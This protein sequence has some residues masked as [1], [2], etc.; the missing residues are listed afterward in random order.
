MKFKI[1]D[2]ISKF[3]IGDTVKM[4]SSE[5]NQVEWIVIA[6]N[7]KRPFKPIVYMSNYNPE[8]IAESEPNITYSLK[9]ANPRRHPY[10]IEFAELDEELLERVDNPIQRLKKRLASGK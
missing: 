4:I 9:I 8:V 1:F 10:A 2:R 7:V 6:I 5:P 3:S